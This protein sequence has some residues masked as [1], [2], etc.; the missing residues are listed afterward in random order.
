ME[1]KR[2]TVCDVLLSIYVHIII[3]YPIFLVAT[4]VV[5]IRGP[6]ILKDSGAVLF[7]QCAKLRVNKLYPVHTTVMRIV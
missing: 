7:D 6:L 1:N 5:L 2:V 3:L 4:D